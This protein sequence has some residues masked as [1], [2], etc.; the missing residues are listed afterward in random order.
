[1]IIAIV[2][3]VLTL[4]TLVIMTQRFEA[5]AQSAPQSSSA[6]GLSQHGLTEMPIC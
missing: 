6:R 3:A 2:F 1:M 4:L 5:E